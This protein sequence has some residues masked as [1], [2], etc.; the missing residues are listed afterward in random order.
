L[1]AVVV[2][3]MLVVVVPEIVRLMM[4]SGL[5]RAQVRT[6]LSGTA[7]ARTDGDG[8]APHGFAGVSR[9]YRPITKKC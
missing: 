5:A 3:V 2:N 6:A 7:P 4:V 1:L 9:T 8:L